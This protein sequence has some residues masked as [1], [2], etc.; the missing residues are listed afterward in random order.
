MPIPKTT[1]LGG[2]DKMPMCEVCGKRPGI[3]ILPSNNPGHFIAVCYPCKKDL[4]QPVTKS[5]LKDIIKEAIKEYDDS[6]R[7]D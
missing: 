7:N 1:D 2:I 3:C 4:T 5:M 6:K